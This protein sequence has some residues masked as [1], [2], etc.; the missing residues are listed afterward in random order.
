M[1]E[2]VPVS[3][4]ESQAHL[5]LEPGLQ[6]VAVPGGHR[7]AL[8][9]DLSHGGGQVLLRSGVTSTVHLTPHL[10]SGHLQVLH[11]PAALTCVLAA[12]PCVSGLT[13]WWIFLM[14]NSSSFRPSTC[15]SRWDRTRTSSS[16]TFLRPLTSASTD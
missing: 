12:A 14:W 13:S 5:G 15:M 7:L 8:L 6:L 10:G 16:K 2:V 3:S 1:E 4:P 9:S 11:T